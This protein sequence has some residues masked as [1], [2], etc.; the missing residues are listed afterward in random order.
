M[1]DRKIWYKYQFHISSLLLL[2]LLSS[3]GAALWLSLNAER[4]RVAWNTSLLP[5]S[6]P[7]IPS[8]FDKDIE[9]ASRS[10]THAFETVSGTEVFSEY[11][12]SGWEWCLL[13][14]DRDVKGG[15]SSVWNSA[16]DS[17]CLPNS[18]QL[19]PP[20]LEAFSLGYFECASSI[21]ALLDEV[22]EED[23]RRRLNVRMVSKRRV[24]PTLILI[25]FSFLLALCFLLR[26]HRLIR[27]KKE[28]G[29]LG[30]R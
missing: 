2:V 12:Q 28:G 7:K 26:M 16:N 6:A 19:P 3:L 8:Y 18:I 13:A 11:H 9:Y 17:A 5:Y 27:R 21:E 10:N 1:N 30:N 23:L 22:R 29:A 4:S 14:F 24:Q 25:G 20:Q 15:N